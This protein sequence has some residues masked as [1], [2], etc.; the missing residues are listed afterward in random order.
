MSCRKDGK[1]KDIYCNQPVKIEI[2]QD[3][4]QRFVPT[5]FSH[6]QPWLRL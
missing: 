1:D 3:K 2:I 5:L 4:W 6:M